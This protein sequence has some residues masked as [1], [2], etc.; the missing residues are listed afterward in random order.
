DLLLGFLRLG[1]SLALALQSILLFNPLGAFPSFASSSAF[2]LRLAL[3]SAASACCH[4]QAMPATPSKLTTARVAA[5]AATDGRR[6]AHFATRSQ[7]PVRRARIGS[8]R[9]QRSRSSAS[10]VAES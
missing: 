2:A 10:A 8:P 6:F 9:C 4:F 3:P 7:A 1:V 5:S